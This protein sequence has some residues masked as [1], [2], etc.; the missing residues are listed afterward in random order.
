MPLQVWGGE[1]RSLE[2]APSPFLCQGEGRGLPSA[3]PPSLGSPLTPGPAPEPPC[4]LPEFITQGPL[5]R[6]TH[7]PSLA[8]SCCGWP[9]PLGAATDSG[10]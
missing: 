5:P 3:L 7:P 4:L 8:Q 6:E 2:R 9:T 1:N 10:V